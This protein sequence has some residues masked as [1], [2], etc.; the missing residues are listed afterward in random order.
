MCM[1]VR[2]FGIFRYYSIEFALGCVHLCI[3]WFASLSYCRFWHALLLHDL[4][5]A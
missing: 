4:D 2:S 1:I 3:L 5:F